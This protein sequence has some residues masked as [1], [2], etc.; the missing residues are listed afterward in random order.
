MVFDVLWHFVV[1]SYSQEYL[2]MVIET[3]I[4]E[5][6]WIESRSFGKSGDDLAGTFDLF[7]GG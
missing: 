7:F 3:S 5:E 6:V 1:E 2:V 4:G